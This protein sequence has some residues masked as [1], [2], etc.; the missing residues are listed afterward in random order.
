MLLSLKLSPY[1]LIVIS[2]LNFDYFVGATIGRPLFFCYNNLTTVGRPYGDFNYVTNTAPNRG[3]HTAS[4]TTPTTADYT[5]L[6][7]PPTPSDTQK[8]LPSRTFPK[9]KQRT[10]KHQLRVTAPNRWYHPIP[11][12]PTNYGWLHRIEDTIQTPSDTQKFLPSFFSKSGP[13]LFAPL[14]SKAAIAAISEAVQPLF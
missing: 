1:C 7:I 4:P 9:T 5:E 8:F 13:N 6:G 14:L 3:Y 11:T 2:C 10:F 12:I